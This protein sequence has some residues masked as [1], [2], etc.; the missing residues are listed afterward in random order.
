MPNLSIQYG[1]NER[2]VR[3]RSY[4]FECVCVCRYFNEISSKGTEVV[5][6]QCA[7]LR[8]VNA[9]PMNKWN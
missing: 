9:L 8:T 2:E 7:D 6:K 1:N 4:F 3:F 5:E